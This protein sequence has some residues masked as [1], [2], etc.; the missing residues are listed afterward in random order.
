[1][2]S[3]STARA[4][5]LYLIGLSTGL[6]FVDQ[7]W[8][9]LAAAGFQLGLYAFS[10]LS[11][12]NLVLALGRLRLLAIVIFISHLL[13]PSTPN[14]PATAL[15]TPWFSLDV[16]LQEWELA[17]T[18]LVRIF[19]LMTASIWV[20]DSERPGEFISALRWIFIPSVVA[21]AIDAGLKLSTRK[22][23]GSG[24]GR[25][26]GRGEGQGGAE[27]G[28][29]R[30]S[31][32]SIRAG[33][34]DFFDDLMRRSFGRAEG[35]LASNYPELSEDRRHDATIILSVVA[36][37]MSLKLLQLLPGLPIAPG[38]KNLVIVPLMIIAALATKARWGAFSA[39]LAI[40]IASFMMGYGK[41]G[42]LEVA[43]FALPGLAADLLAPVFLVGNRRLIL[44]RLALFGGVIG[45]TRFAANFLILM[46]AGSPAL[47]WVLFSPML[48]SQILFGALS[49]ILGVYVLDKIQ[50]GN[51]LQ[52]SLTTRETQNE[53]DEG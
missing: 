1:M 5:I 42:I 52:S 45:L 47:A 26:G 11:F 50:N 27:N 43:H 25:G 14:S 39:G 31:W 48:V 3:S 17:S 9:L 20:R 6:F 36:A 15:S 37:V 41:F 22:G 4:K 33:K 23:G 12:R 35:F 38:H 44:L 7:L 13:F 21:I 10:G 46:L 49:S 19:C 40:G 32:R 28:R 51:I 30:V 24:G 29:V 8:F 18:M 53:T 16:Y 34:M 2:D